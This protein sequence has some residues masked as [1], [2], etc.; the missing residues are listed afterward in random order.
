[1]KAMDLPQRHRDTELKIGK[2]AKKKWY[3][4][5][6]TGSMRNWLMVEGIESPRGAYDGE[7][8]ERSGRDGAGRFQLT[9]PP[10]GFF[11]SVDGLLAWRFTSLDLY[12]KNSDRETETA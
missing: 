8:E 9:P 10:P 4:P 6:A 7:S 1:M 5:V 2:G 3:S 12:L 11:I